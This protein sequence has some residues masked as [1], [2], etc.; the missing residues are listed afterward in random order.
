MRALLLVNPTSA[1]RTGSRLL[2]VFSP[3]LLTA[4][5]RG[6]GQFA[7]ALGMSRACHSCC[8]CLQVSKIS[9]VDLAGSERADSTGAKGTRLK[10]RA[11][12]GSGRQSLGATCPFPA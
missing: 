10:V 6:G 7:H 1:S 2:K 4:Q 9:L 8:L 5:L 11:W 12:R 3:T